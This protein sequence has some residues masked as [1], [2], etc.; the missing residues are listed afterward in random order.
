MKISQVFKDFKGRKGSQ[1]ER[2]RGRRRERRAKSV[3]L[4]TSPATC[5]YPDITGFYP[6]PQEMRG[7]ELDPTRNQT[8][9]E[10]EF[11]FSAK[12]WSVSNRQLRLRPFDQIP[13]SRTGGLEKRERI[14]KVK[15][16]RERGK[17]REVNKVSCSLLVGAL[18][19]VVCD[20][21]RPGTKGSQSQLLGL[22]HQWGSWSLS[23]RSGQDVSRSKEESPPE[24]P[25]VAGRGTPSRAQ[26]WGLV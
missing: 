17:R 16:R 19:P 15:E 23:T 22:I 12:R 4:H 3:A 14:G 7:L 13:V 10:P 25:F 2:R 18:W 11:K 8:S 9:T 24:S 6:G 26:N 21:R 1:V 5:R 20:R